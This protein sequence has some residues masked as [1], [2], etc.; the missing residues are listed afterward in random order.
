M[1]DAVPKIPITRAVF[2][3]EEARA[4]AAV[5]ASGW[6]VQ[7]PKVAE[8]EAG[9]RGFTGLPEAVA[10]TSCTTGLHLALLAEGI[11]PGDEVIVPSFT[12]VASANAV[13]YVGATPILA[14]VSLETF[15]LI[16]DEIE[17]L[18]TPR[19]RAVMPVHLFGLAAEMEP[20]LA[21]A[22]RH[23]LKV[24]EDCA[25]ALGTLYKGQHVGALGDGGAFSFH[26]R[27]AITTGEGGMY[28]TAD[29]AKAAR[30]RALR[31]HGAARSDH[32][33]H[34]AKGSALLP[35]FDMVGYNYRMTD[36]QAAVGVAQLAKLERILAARIARARR[37]DEQ[38]A[39]VADLT[40]PSQPE[41]HRHS[42]QSYVC[43]LHADGDSEAA[44]LTA[45]D[46]RNAVM[47]AL[48]EEGIAT[49][50]GTHAVHLLDY[51]RRTYGHAPMDLPG[52]FAADRL[53]L[54]LPLYASMTDAE[55]DRVVER[56][57]WHLAHH[58]A[59]LHAG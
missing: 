5:L 19:T 51:Y 33:R 58:H 9:F 43:R 46:R 47:A 52:A 12:W 7:G 39:G 37:Y 26:P 16:P 4:V 3:D 54:S 36:L 20:I 6:V 27:K 56:L 38:L 50:Q 18:R 10:C 17:R 31:D 35:V 44:I 11:G 22:S 57:D 42:Y 8:F 49:R 30:A 55:Q 29:P 24:V 25:C 21:L 41:G 59:R 13:T 14:D 40:P 1:S 15:N 23:G 53:S 32:A 2:D 45:H 48:E 28:T 34:T